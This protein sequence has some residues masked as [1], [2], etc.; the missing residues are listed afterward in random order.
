[1]PDK[2][3]SPIAQEI[4]RKAQECA[5]EL[6]HDY[7]GCEH[8]LLALARGPEG[9]ARRSL[10]E[11]GMTEERLLELIE[12]KQ[13]RGNGSGAPSQG[14]TARSRGAIEMA[15]AEALRGSGTAIEPEHL[16]MG[17]LR[18]GENVAV[19][20]L[21]SA[22]VD[23][24]KLYTSLLRRRSELSETHRREQPRPRELT[25]KREKGLG[26]FTRDLTE[27]ARCGKLDPVVGRDAEIE[28]TIAIL[29]RRT[30][31]NPVLIGE[32][33]VGKTA[34]A[35][36]L[37]ERIVAGDVPEELLPKR[38]LSLDL[39]CVL[40]GTKY[41]GEF[42]ERFRNLI[43]EVKRDG[44]VILFIDEL[45]T[46]IGA[47]SAE[48]A[49]DASNLIKPALGRGE[50]SVIGAT[51]LGEY[52][53]H[54][55]KDAALER[56]FQSVTVAEPTAQQALAIL[57]G[58]RP[59][60]EQHHGLV[61][62]DE[63][64]AAA[65]ELSKRYIG[66]RFLPDKAI[67]LIDEA[68]SC[69][70]LET[71]VASPQLRS[72]EEKLAELH[73]EKSE[74]IARQEFERAA[75][76]RDIESDFCAQA[77]Q[78]REQLRQSV[79]AS[80]AHVTREDVAKVVAAWTGIPVTRVGESESA[81]LMELESAL[82]ARVVGQDEAVRAVAAAIRRGRVGIKDPARPVGSFL[83]LGPTGVGKT[84][85]CRALAQELFSQEEALLRF[86]MSEYMEKHSV[87]RL[88]GSPP[89]YV[90]YG[91][92]GELSEKVRRRPYSLVLFDEIEKAHSDVLDLLLQIL[93][94]GTLTDAQG[95]KVDFRNTVV[96]MTGNV[97]AKTVLAGV[98]RLGF[99][100][101]DEDDETRVKEVVLEELRRS[102]R[103]E[104]L[105]R[106]DETVVFRRLGQEDI[107]CIT[108]KMLA[109]T[110]LRA[111]ALGIELCVDD[112]AVHWLVSRGFDPRYGARPLRRLI[113][114]EVETVLAEKFL[115][116]TLTN[117]DRALVTTMQ[118][119]LVIE[120]CEAS[121]PL[122]HSMQA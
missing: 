82:C 57:H 106:I 89:G 24:K 63:A 12:Q 66:E 95:R 68:A 100:R 105:N 91:E 41:R 85:L 11:A 30:K 62:T 28:R 97:G 86:D 109:A 96:V 56:R 92:S 69:V 42:E 64:L 35:E 113:A 67:D 23:T 15:V 47:G 2:K 88:I 102:F 25:G 110:E 84:E 112:E 103:P 19:Q 43:E 6:G 54:I 61:L 72:I 107:A 29:V 59:R 53:K 10:N 76:L 114:H 48:G 83:F 121:Q 74:A 120:R 16:L 81:Q 111:A 51:T 26:E 70:R 50:I 44:N 115:A 9:T 37:A 99:A 101:A 20:I 52:R 18:E 34:I 21:I 98:S 58:L 7:V 31:N 116:G 36:G 3:F 122:S 108:R 87:S 1:M 33:G 49:I 60:Y 77:E 79:A 39:A 8:L 78:E 90:G 71:K 46:V 38:I 22:G 40:A 13:G 27:M 55:E 73:R 80:S 119:E 75:R 4:L 117:G 14:L 65:V 32:P 93:D 5:V 17:I 104:F 118:G 45:H 94:S